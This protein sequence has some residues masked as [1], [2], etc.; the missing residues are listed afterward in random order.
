MVLYWCWRTLYP[1]FIRFPR[2]RACPIFTRVYFS[3]P[4]LSAGEKN[5]VPKGPSAG[6]GEKS[7]GRHDHKKR[8]IAG[9]KFSK[10]TGEID[11]LIHEFKLYVIYHSIC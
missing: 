10:I 9:V 1:F 8:S 4:T 3:P 6:A 7:V 11:S 5:K 2:P